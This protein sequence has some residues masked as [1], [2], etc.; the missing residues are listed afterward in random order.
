MQ[1]TINPVHPG[2]NEVSS[3]VWKNF[4]ETCCTRYQ[5]MC[6]VSQQLQNQTPVSTTHKTAALC[7][8]YCTLLSFSTKFAPHMTREDQLSLSFS[9]FKHFVTCESSA[10][11]TGQSL[12]SDTSS[13]FDQLSG[14]V[15]ILSYCLS[16]LADPAGLFTIILS[17]ITAYALLVSLS[18][19]FSLSSLPTPCWSQSPSFFPSPALLTATSTAGLEVPLDYPCAA[20]TLLR[21][22]ACF[23]WNVDGES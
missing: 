15:G 10:I 2:S 6:K 19:S 20:K 4:A 13:L 1:D 16:S 17:V 22:S 9:N 3:T 5:K 14:V 21:F 8:Y 7:N 12:H 18:P 11:R 23:V